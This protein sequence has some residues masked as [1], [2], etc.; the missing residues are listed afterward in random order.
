MLQRAA[1]VGTRGFDSQKRLQSLAP[2]P[3]RFF[4]P[5]GHYPIREADAEAS[6][7]PKTIDVLNVGRFS[8]V[9]RVDLF[10]KV[11]AELKKSLPGLKAVFV[12][13]TPEDN[14]FRELTLELGLES[15]VEFRPYTLDLEPWYRKSKVFLLTSESEGLPMVMI[16]AMSYGVPCVVPRVG[17]I[18]DVAVHGENALLANPL[19]VQDFYRQ[20][21]RL[22]TDPLL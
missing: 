15:A 22:L 5:H 3:L 21:L 13:G 14:P 20:T 16:E 2:S 10:L 7:V 4:I 18:P 17:D 19:D 6:D 8:K 1:W 11:L 12:G 9:K